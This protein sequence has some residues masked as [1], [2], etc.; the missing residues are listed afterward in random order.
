[1]SY[2]LVGKYEE[3]LVMRHREWKKYWS[4]TNG[5][6]ADKWTERRSHYNWLM[7]MGLQET[8]A[9]ILFGHG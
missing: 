3:E 5:E 1:M 4:H 9:A 6:T 8:A 7:M 2:K